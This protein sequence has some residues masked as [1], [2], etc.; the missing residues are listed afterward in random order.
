MG[1]KFDLLPP[2][3]YDSGVVNWV[4]QSFIRI[5]QAFARAIGGGA[6]TTSPTSPAAGDIFTNTTAK[7]LETTPDGIT[8]KKVGSYDELTWSPVISQ[9]GALG[10]TVTYANYQYEGAWITGELLLTLTGAGTANTKITITPPLNAE[11]NLSQA[12]GYGYIY[13][14]SSNTR[15]PVIVFYAA[16]NFEMLDATQ[17]T[18]GLSIGQTG[19]AFAVALANGDAVTFNFRYRWAN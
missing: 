5:Q 11:S 4:A 3:Q 2:A 12:C 17:G 15:V 19:T 13:D 18:V 8:F 6:G 10:R 7:T 9:P 14:A 1:I 16:N